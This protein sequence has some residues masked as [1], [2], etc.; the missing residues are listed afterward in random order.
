MNPESSL[1]VD[2]IN[3]C[4]VV[5]KGCVAVHLPSSIDGDDYRRMRLRQWTCRRLLPIPVAE[6]QGVGGRK[7]RRH[8]SNMQIDVTKLSPENL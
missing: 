1:L 2:P 6:R 7:Q 5:T 3:P 4:P 8:L